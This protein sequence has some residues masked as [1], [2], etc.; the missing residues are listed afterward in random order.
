MTCP[1]GGTDASPTFGH[2]LTAVAPYTVVID[3]GDGDVYRDDDQHLAAIFGH[4]YD[5]AGTFT[6]KAVLT[7]ARG[8]TATANCL[9]P[10][11]APA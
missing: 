11:S 6:V 5:S 3:Y 7:D 2:Q 10:L 4:T 8:R 1:A 9:Y